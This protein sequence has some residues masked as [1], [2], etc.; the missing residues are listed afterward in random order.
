M[1]IGLPTLGRWWQLWI[2]SYCDV[3]CFFLLVYNDPS[4]ET[5]PFLEDAKLFRLPVY[6]SGVN[7]T[8]RGLVGDTVF[9]VLP[10]VKPLYTFTITIA[11]QSVCPP[12]VWCSML[13][14]TLTFSRQVF[15]T[16]LWFS[17]TYKSFLIALTLCGYSSFMFGWHVHEKAVLLILVPLR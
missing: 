13:S 16:K 3:G 10:N 7:S 2:E 1:H 15:L 9:A 12:D 4:Q 14:P 5:K 6:L 17:P 11:Y 8:S